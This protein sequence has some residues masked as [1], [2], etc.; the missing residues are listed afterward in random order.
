M[1]DEEEREMQATNRRT[2]LF[3]AFAFGLCA[4]WLL[5]RYW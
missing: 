5:C 4:G 3:W 1:N 2:D